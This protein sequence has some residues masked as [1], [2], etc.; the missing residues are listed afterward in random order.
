MAAVLD[1][2]DR[3]ALELS[4][5]SDSAEIR[6][7]WQTRASGR[8]SLLDAVGLGLSQMSRSKNPR[9]APLIL[10][11]DKLHS[12]RLQVLP[13]EGLPKLSVYWRNRYRAPGN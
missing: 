3:P 7:A 4:W 9:R 8:T 10:S 13:P 11:N 1:P 6:R 2:Y 12:I 5:T